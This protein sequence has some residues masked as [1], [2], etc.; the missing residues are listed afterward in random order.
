MS[1]SPRK[2]L[3]R[4]LDALRQIQETTDRYP[5]AR[6]E[7]EATLGSDGLAELD[8]ARAILARTAERLEEGR[9]AAPARAELSG[10]SEDHRNG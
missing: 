3:R 7:L 9:T 5:D 1:S 8:R 2:L 10:P 6:R 4:A